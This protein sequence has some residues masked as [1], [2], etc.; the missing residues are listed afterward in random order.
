[1]RS[2]PAAAA[3][4]S[5]AIAAACAPDAPS[6]I[7]GRVPRIRAALL[8]PNI[9]NGL[10]LRATFS[11]EH[12]DSA[13]VMYRGG[14][15]VD[16]TPF[17]P[18]A[19][20]ARTS[21]PLLGLAEATTY[22][23]VIEARGR[24]GRALSDTIEAATG[25]LPAALRSLR[26]E[27]TGAPTP[28]YVLLSPLQFDGDTVGYTI[29][30]DGRG[31]IAWYRAFHDGL[32]VVETKQQPNGNFT[33]H[34]GPTGRPP[35]LTRYYEFTPAGDIVREYT[36]PPP[37]YL[38]NHELL[39]TTGSDA[40]PTAHYFAFDFRM[41]DTFPPARAGRSSVAGH[42]LIRRRSGEQPE[43]VWNSWD[44][45]SVE[46]VIEPGSSLSIDH[47][48]S[49]DIDRD[50]NYVVSWRNL[51]EV[52][53]IDARTG[54]TIWRLGGRN[55]QFTFVNDPLGGFSGQH[56]ARMLP[57]GDLLLYDNGWRHSP[58]QSRAVQYR[59]DVAARTATLVWEFRHV[60]PIFTTYVGSVQRHASGNTLIGF[61]FA[62]QMTEVTPGGT[63]A[64]EGTLRNGAATVR[65]YR[66]IRVPSLYRHERP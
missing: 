29:A 43:V 2:R 11:A 26:L 47:P 15:A 3:A 53:K 62:G 35:L 8:E 55:N 20:G 21:V 60:P 9:Y 52:T 31:A 65:F 18:A 23:A 34:V 56:S 58:S 49:I 7:E 37:L 45:F 16:T 41:L 33:A 1:M 25:A 40:G 57:D 22:R 24:E 28:G 61:G 54:A 38:D 13:R 36:A 44:H 27:V 39:L 66:A 17:F 46:D 64:W 5:I 30:F 6:F 12:A 10:S 42:Q 19:D 32:P 14:D 51:G 48:N 59:L 63:A 50:G 4:A